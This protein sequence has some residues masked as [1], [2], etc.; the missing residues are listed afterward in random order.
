MPSISLE[1][2]Q[3]ITQVRGFHVRAMCETSTDL[4]HLPSGNVAE[5]PDLKKWLVRRVEC[6]RGHVDVNVEVLPAFSK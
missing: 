1:W 5:R 2:L 3:A 4:V 6:M